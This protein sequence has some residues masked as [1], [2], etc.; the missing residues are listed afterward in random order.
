MLGVGLFYSKSRIGAIFV[1]LSIGLTGVASAQLAPACKAVFTDAR[2]SQ[3]LSTPAHLLSP[4][5]RRFWEDVGAQ[6]KHSLDYDF[7]SPANKPLYS[8]HIQAGHP[9][10]A[11]YKSLGFETTP[12]N[13]F[14][15]PPL[16]QLLTNLHLQVDGLNRQLQANG[17]D[18]QL[19]PKMILDLLNHQTHD[20][21]VLKLDPL[22]EV[23]VPGYRLTPGENILSV[24]DFYLMATKG[25]L[26]I[27]GIESA[28][29]APR[30]L[31]EKGRH[32]PRLLENFADKPHISEFLHDLGHLSGLIQNP[33]FAAAYFRVYQSYF[34]RWGRKSSKEP[35]ASLEQIAE[36][37]TPFWWRT[38]YF[39]ESSWVTKK[40][41]QKNL[42]DLVILQ[43][44]IQSR[45]SVTK[46]EERLALIREL[47]QLRD[48]WWKL[49]TPLGGAANDMI[50]YEGHAPSIRSIFLLSGAL[51]ELNRFLDRPFEPGT[52]ASLN[53]VLNFLKHSPRLTVEQWELF[54]KSDNWQTT[55]GFKILQQIFTEADLRR[56]EDWNHLY[57]FLY[58]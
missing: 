46:S 29:G 3:A 30:Q 5:A 22:A 52:E 40:D 15:A 13:T 37:G 33:D 21:Q 41:Y 56:L 19:Q 58:Q 54:A 35:L 47:K 6:F 20:K 26:P 49:F 34:E 17:V 53:I 45:S 14:K 25:S 7:N 18:I 11:F 27:G 51:G 50:S 9:A 36:P 57:Q 43:S 16:I 39:S 10:V 8:K 2:A 28:V 38:F 4:E 44:L 24:A 12:G 1:L 42:Q 31:L 55:P 23:S 32:N 48:N